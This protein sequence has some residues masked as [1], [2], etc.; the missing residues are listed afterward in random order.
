MTDPASAD[1]PV[2]IDRVDFTRSDRDG[3]EMRLTGRW[4]A[5][6]DVIG[7]APLLVVQVQGRRHR[8]TPAPDGHPLAPGSWAATFR[9]PPWAQPRREGQAAL[10]VGTSVVPVPLSGVSADGTY[11]PYPAQS[12]H[13][14]PP[15]PALG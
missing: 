9:I 10:W 11:P 5:D 3:I 1:L 7:F 4:L 14:P 12:A 8:F 6:T 2:A 13:R 15:P